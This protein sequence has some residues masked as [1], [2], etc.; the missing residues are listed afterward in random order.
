MSASIC[1]FP[2]PWPSTSQVSPGPGSPGINCVCAEHSSGRWLCGFLL[3]SVFK[4][5]GQKMQRGH[6]KRCHSATHRSWRAGI[7]EGHCKY[8]LNRSS[9]ACPMEPMTSWASPSQ[10]S[11]MW[12]AVGARD[13]GSLETDTGATQAPP[14][15]GWK[16]AAEGREGQGGAFHD[17][18]CQLCVQLNPWEPPEVPFHCRDPFLNS[19]FSPKVK[20][21]FVS[22]F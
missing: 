13:T 3:F 18:S 9:K 11:R 14:S 7:L 4:R 10:H 5:K 16:P 17:M 8:C 15:W 6:C 2:E 22:T 19:L 20:V 21:L 1:Q 12:Q